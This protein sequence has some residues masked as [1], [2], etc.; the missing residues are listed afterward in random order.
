ME[1]VTTV[2]QVIGFAFV[3]Y[4]LVLAARNGFTQALVRDRQTDAEKPESATA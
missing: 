1:I 3:G 4:G 2:L